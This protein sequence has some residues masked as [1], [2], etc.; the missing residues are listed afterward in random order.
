MQFQAGV[1]TLVSQ[2]TAAGSPAVG[3]SPVTVSFV[4]GPGGQSYSW[5]FGD[6]STS[7]SQNPTHTYAPPGTYTVVLTVT[8]SNGVKTTAGLTVTVEPSGFP[9]DSDNDGYP[10]EMESAFGSDPYNPASTPFGMAPPVK[11]SFI[12]VSSLRIRLNFA[13]PVGHDSITLAGYVPMSTAFSPAGQR[14]LL[15]IGGVCK[16]FMMDRRGN[17]NDGGDQLRIGLISH[18]PLPPL[19][20]KIVGNWNARYAIVLRNGTFAAT[21][22]DKGFVSADNG[23]DIQGVALQVPI[24]V[25]VN[26]RSYQVI[27]GQIYRAKAGQWGQS[28]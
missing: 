25:I 18:A 16:A 15:D 12:A 14:L 11:A 2:A 4:G 28:R 13:R 1:A 7:T 6:G 21:L 24:T 26:G 22:K 23:K 27:A 5:D 20:S 19:N 3:V 9:L 8:D 10:D 17:S